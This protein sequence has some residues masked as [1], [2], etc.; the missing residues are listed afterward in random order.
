MWLQEQLME[1]YKQAM[2]DK[3]AVKK[4]ILNFIISQIKYKKI[5][6]QKDP[7]DEDVIQIIKKEI[8]SRQE[9]ISFLEKAWNTEEIA[10]ENQRIGIMQTYLPAMMPREQLEK[11]VKDI[12]SSQGIEDPKKNRWVVIWAVMKDHKAVVDGA[13]LNDIINNL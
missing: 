1:D 5:E 12:L 13:V 10:I 2:R 6:L 8:K 9:S 11:I 4:E 7:T 3:D